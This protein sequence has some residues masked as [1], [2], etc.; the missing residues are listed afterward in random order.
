MWLQTIRSPHTVEI[1]ITPTMYN[2]P[3]G[4]PV[5]CLRKITAKLS[6]AISDTAAAMP[7]QIGGAVG[8]INSDMKLGRMTRSRIPASEIRSA[9]RR[10]D[11][12]S[13]PG[14]LGRFCVIGDS[15]RRIDNSTGRNEQ[16]SPVGK[17]ENE[18]LARPFRPAEAL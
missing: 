11:A 13:E 16:H 18:G 14:S 1:T 15:F 17:T 6:T 3:N 2:V 10:P 8:R 5:S 7:N 4:R 12:S 9:K